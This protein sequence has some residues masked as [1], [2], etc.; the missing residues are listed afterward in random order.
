AYWDGVARRDNT[1]PDYTVDSARMYE[2]FTKHLFTRTMH[3]S[4]DPNVSYQG[5]VLLQPEIVA[6]AESECS[7]E[8]FE[9]VAEQEPGDVADEEPAE[10]DDDEDEDLLLES[11]LQAAPGWQPHTPPA[12]TTEADYEIA[13]AWSLP[14][15]TIPPATTISPLADRGSRG[16]VDAV[17]GINNRKEF[18]VP[19]AIWSVKNCRT[20]IHYLWREQSSRNT[21]CPNPASHPK[22]DLLLRNAIKSYEARLVVTNTTTGQVRTTSCAVRDPYTSRQFL[23]MIAFTWRMIPIPQEPGKRSY[24]SKRFPYIREHLNLLARHH[25]LL[26]DE[27]IRNLAISD[28]FSAF[29]RHIVRGIRVLVTDTPAYRTRLKKITRRKKGEVSYQIGRTIAIS[30]QSPNYATS[31]VMRPCDVHSPRVTHMGRHSGSAEAYHLGLSIDH[32]R[33]LGRWSMGQMEKYYMPRNPIIG[34]YYMAHFYQPNDPYFLPR[35]LVMPPLSLQRRIFPWIEQSFEKDDPERTESWIKACND[36]MMAVDPGEPSDQEFHRDFNP[37]HV[38]ER[39]M[40]GDGKRLMNTATVDRTAFLSA[41]V[42]MR[43]V[44]LQDAVL[45]LRPDAQGRTLSNTLFTSDSVKTI[46]FEDEEFLKFQADLLRAMDEY[47][48]RPE[49]VNPAFRLRSDEFIQALNSGYGHTSRQNEET[50]QAIATLRDEVRTMGGQLSNVGAQL[51]H[52]ADLVLNKATE[53]ATRLSLTEVQRQRQQH[54]HEANRSQ[55]EFSRSLQEAERL[56][57]VE[58]QL[59]GQLQ[60]QS[61]Q[62][63]QQP[64]P[65][66]PSPQQPPSRQSPLPQHQP[67]LL[68]MSPEEKDQLGYKMLPDDGRL[69]IR[70]AWDEFH[71]PVAEAIKHDKK[72][73]YSDKRKK[74]YRRRREFIRLLQ[75]EAAE[76]GIGAMVFV[77]QISIEKKDRSINSVLLDLKK[78]AKDKAVVTE[79]LPTELDMLTMVDE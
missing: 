10:D 28:V 39:L 20:A 22:E 23:H 58:I 66:Q 54:P 55:Q 40:K 68:P 62:Q 15:S 11:D 27:D 47:A 79:N 7:D 38:K 42:R 73:P 76:K 18:D 26:R 3:R 12:G 6:P 37:A 69:T 24:D 5:A 50:H 67:M 51:N 8:E 14:S 29:T 71:G 56:H 65:Q 43:R 77:N 35:D 70:Q 13:Q 53:D 64:S 59:L 44:I 16:D 33:L 74:T 60:P 36:D 1:P 46:F 34:P 63:P 72:W 30:N 32:L 9:D 25:M 21:R 57:Q 49:L 31:S 52:L 41:L 45:Y 75:T 2:Y 17:E 4:I 78:K 48:E 19:A 61:P